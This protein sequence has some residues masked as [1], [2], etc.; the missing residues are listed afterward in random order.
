MAAWNHVPRTMVKET[1]NFEMFILEIVHQA[2]KVK[3]F[4]GVRTRKR[5]KEENCGKVWV[6]NARSPVRLANV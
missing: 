4:R 1:M 2:F 3:S 5:I 6:S